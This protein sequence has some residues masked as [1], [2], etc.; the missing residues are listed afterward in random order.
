MR[1]EKPQTPSMDIR[2]M[3]YAEALAHIREVIADTPEISLE[4]QQREDGPSVWLEGWYTAKDLEA[5]AVWVLA[6]S[7]QETD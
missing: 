1:H 7:G 2:P 5:L 3:N 4:V 6:N